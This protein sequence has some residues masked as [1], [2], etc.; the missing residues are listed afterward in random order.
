MPPASLSQRLWAALID[1]LVLGGW[2]VLVALLGPWPERLPGQLRA[3]IWIGPCLL[4]E[5]VSLRVF[6]RTVGQQLLGLRVISTTPGRPGLLRL[7]ARHLSK[8]LF[9]GAGPLYT[10][11][12]PRGQA[13]HDHLFRTA[14]VTQAPKRTE[15]P[16][17]RSPLRAF[18]VSFGFSVFAGL[19]AV[20]VLSFVVGVGLAV[21]GHGLP[22][23]PAA[24][25][26]VSLPIAIAY[27]WAQLRVL[28]RGARGRLP[29]TGG[30]VATE[31]PA[32]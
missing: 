1:A 29:G 7:V 18:V 27:L 31:S 17:L 22:E 30:L 25:A 10:L 32:A 19:G 26:L 13:L 20:L 28:H 12:S 14:V 2:I 11:F 6:G 15:I 5:P 3:L 8:A 21:A 24:E 16:R 4:L 23:G 9:F